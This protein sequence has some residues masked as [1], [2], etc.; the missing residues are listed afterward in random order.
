V[1]ACRDRKSV[2]LVLVGS[3]PGRPA[4]KG[5]GELTPNELEVL[6]DVRERVGDAQYELAAR[7][8]QAFREPTPTRI[9]EL[10]D[11]AMPALPHLAKA[12][13]RFLQEYPWTIDGLSRTERRLLQLADGG[14]TEL[15]AAFP[16]MHEGEDAYFVTDGTISSIAE[17]LSR[18][19][20]AL[21]EGHGLS[22]DGRCRIGIAHRGG[23]RRAC[24][25]R[26]RIAA[27]GIDR[28]LGGVHL[29]GRGT[30][31]RWDPQLDRVA[32]R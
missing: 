28:W 15:L 26:D 4:F 5:L 2:S 30:M 11:S 27:Y 23:A 9:D 3:F 10:R 12:L 29:K 1:T 6:L 8:W 16:R 20:P 21:L 22:S 14:P 13:S 18:T 31:W 19:S 25:R 17:D 7:A 32:E 24:R